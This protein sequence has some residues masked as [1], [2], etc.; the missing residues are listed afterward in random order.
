MDTLQL[1]RCLWEDSRTRHQFGDVLSI[2][3]LPKTPVEPGRNLYVINTD[4][5][6]GRGKHWVLMYFTPDGSGEFFDS[7]GLDMN[8]YGH[9]LED[10]MYLNAANTVVDYGVRLQGDGSETCGFY[11]LYYALFRCRGVSRD[12]IIHSFTPDY[13][14]NDA[15]VTRFVKEHFNVV[16]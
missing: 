6:T 10:F 16:V 11:C 7:M 12:S 8:A 3:V 15:I 5:H 14:L 9:Q 1:I 2:D 4:V 13:R